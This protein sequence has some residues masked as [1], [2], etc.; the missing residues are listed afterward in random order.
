MTIW[1]KIPSDVNMHILNLCDYM[2]IVM[3]L[4]QLIAKDKLHND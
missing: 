1:I 4:R 2:Q 3:L